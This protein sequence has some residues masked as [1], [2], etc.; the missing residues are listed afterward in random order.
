MT[1]AAATP[2]QRVT[3][4]KRSPFTIN[5]QAI[6]TL[7]AVV[8]FIVM[9]IIGELMFGTYLRLGFISSLLMDHSYLIIL[10]VAMTFPILTG[11]IDLSVGAIVAITG[12]VA[13]KLM[14]A[15]VPSWVAIIVMLLIG[16]AFGALAGILIEQFNMQP[17]IATLS[18]MFLA[19]GIA[20]IISTDSLTVPKD[21]NFSWLATDIHLID[22]PKISNDLTVDLGVFVAVIVVVIGY[23]VLH[24]TRTGRTIYAIGGSRSS[25]ELMGLPVK[26]TQ[27]SIYIISALLAS[28]AS[29]VYMASMGNAKNVVGV[30]WELDAV[31]SVVIG[32]TLISGGFGYVLGS[33]IGALVRSIIDPLTSDFS[34]PAEAVT[35]VVG[36]MILIF[37]VLQRAVMAV[38]RR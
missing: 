35:I 21:N 1:S 31:A 20:S 30:G 16:V 24:K 28:V 9:I 2:K 37:V 13:A 3:A 29:I 7:A 15:G 11:G 32:G 18:T 6:P 27:Y 12:V 22:N 8:I 14:I 10:A 34:V 5:P 23:I 33:V 26:R 17:F 36:V 38:K 25:A 4:K 19:R